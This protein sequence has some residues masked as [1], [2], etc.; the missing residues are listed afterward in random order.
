KVHDFWATINATENQ[1]ICLVG[2]DNAIPELI[3]T[4]TTTGTCQYYQ[5]GLGEQTF[6][7]Q[8]PESQTSPYY[9]FDIQ[10][11]TEV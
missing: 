10:R 5:F 3:K 9:D 1:T 4:W 7:W 6:E 2:G 8:I 11:R